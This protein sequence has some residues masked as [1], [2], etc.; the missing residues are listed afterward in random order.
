MDQPSFIERLADEERPFTL[1]VEGVPVQQFR[2]TAAGEAILFQRG[3]QHQQW[4]LSQLYEMLAGPDPMII[5]PSSTHLEYFWCHASV[6]KRIILDEYIRGATFSLGSG[7]KFDDETCHAF[8][9]EESHVNNARKI[10][11]F[12]RDDKFAKDRTN[13]R[14]VVD[15]LLD[16]SS[17]D[18]L[19][20]G[21]QLIDEGFVRSD[22]QLF[23]TDAMERLLALPTEFQTLALYDCYLYEDCLE[24]FGRVAKANFDLR[25]LNWKCTPAGKRALHAGM[26]L[27]S[28]PSRLSID[29]D[30]AGLGLGFLDANTKLRRLFWRSVA[31]YYAHRVD[32]ELLP[33]L[34]PGLVVLRVSCIVV[35]L[36]CWK[37]VLE[38]VVLRLPNLIKIKICTTINGRHGRD[39]LE[40]KLWTKALVD[41][42]Q[43]N[44]ALF[45]M[46][47]DVS[48]VSHLYLRNALEFL[49]G[50][51]P[52]DGLEEAELRDRLVAFFNTHPSRYIFNDV[53]DGLPPL[54]NIHLL[55]IDI[56]GWRDEAL[57]NDQVRPHL[58]RN[59]VNSLRRRFAS[60]PAVLAAIFANMLGDPT[61]PAGLD[62]YIIRQDPAFL[63]ERALAGLLQQQGNV[64]TESSE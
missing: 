20:S 28:G 57:W 61:L 23:S 63:I 47:V 39:E 7:S 48:Q 51:A 37:R 6:Y 24:A 40:R 27:N 15:G 18:C 17:T 32:E 45:A 14:Q 44:P 4:S 34:T 38:L 10:K 60:A 22:R 25:L 29:M 43:G 35:N 42:F 9:N 59:K 30:D 11:L 31:L 41:A 12:Y 8:L 2:L 53:R 49:E 64:D 13:I 16:M 5:F 58:E 54:D 33:W 56:G 52:G 36:A 21:V 19:I 1:D 26:N 46:E 3:G 62:Y 50:H 55:E